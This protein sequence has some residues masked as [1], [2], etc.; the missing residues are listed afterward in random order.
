MKTVAL[1]GEPGSGKTTLFRWLLKDLPSRTDFAYGLLKGECMVVKDRMVYVLGSYKGET[2]DGTDRLSMAVQKDALK[3]IQTLQ[4]TD[5][6]LF[7][8][9]RLGNEKFFEAC[10]ALGPFHLFFL[11]T[12][13]ATLEIRRK[14]R[15]S[16]QDPTWL[17]GRQTKVNRLK[18]KFKAE[19]IFTS[20]ARMTTDARVRLYEEIT[21]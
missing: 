8:G 3:F 4:E 10:K 1:I 11:D 7:E 20:S 2:F 14:E 9:D 18:D 5:V 15:G 13:E 21:N 16:N 17:K 6:L 12:A 19:E